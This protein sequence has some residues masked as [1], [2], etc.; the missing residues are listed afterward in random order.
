[1]I[2]GRRAA[3]PRESLDWLDRTWPMLA[4][5]QARSPVRVYVTGDDWVDLPDWPP[6]TAPRVLYLQPAGGWRDRPPPATPAAR[7]RFRYDP[8]DPTPTLGGRWCWPRRAATA[9][10]VA[11]ARRADVLS[12]TRPAAVGPLR[13]RPPRRRTGARRRHP[14]RRRVRAGQRGRLPGAFAQ[15]QRRLPARD[16]IVGTG[17]CPR[18]TRRDRAPLPGGFE[19]PGA[20]RRRRPSAVRPQPRHRRTD[21]HRAADGPRHP[22]RASRRRRSLPADSVRRRGSDRQPTARRTRSAIPR[23]VASSC[24]GAPVRGD[25]DVAPSWCSPRTPMCGPVAPV[26]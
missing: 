7:R 25:R 1:M 24:T 17:R 16:H 23:N 20:R 9:T 22:H 14:A 26:R 13:L 12:F 2:T 19:N 8:A 10:T 3:V 6:A 15:C 18:R 11:L 21:A 4:T 5:G